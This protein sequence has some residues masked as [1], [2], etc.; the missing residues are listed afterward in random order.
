MSDYLSS[1]FVV[2]LL[3]A[4]NHS[5]LNH[6]VLS[7]LPFLTLDSQEFLMITGGWV[8]PSLQSLIESKDLFGDI[9]TSPEREGEL[10]ESLYNNYTQSNYFTIK[11]SANFFYETKKHHGFSIIHL[12]MRSLPKNLTSLQDI[13]LTVKGTPEIIA[14]S[15]TKLQEKNIYNIS[16]PGYAF[17]NTNSPTSA[18]GVGLIFLKN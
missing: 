10:Q 6:N 12:N 18:G 9:I 1:L 13:I 15:E 16:I 7:E 11:Q 2:L 5:E 14:L 4:F 17:L 8:H 3:I